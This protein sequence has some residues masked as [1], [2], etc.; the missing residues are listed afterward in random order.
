MRW[1]NCA[2]NSPPFKVPQGHEKW[3]ISIAYLRLLVSNQYELWDYL[4][5]F[6]R[7]SGIFVLKNIQALCLLTSLRV[8]AFRYCNCTRNQET[9]TMAQPENVKNWQY[10]HCIAKTVSLLFLEY[11]WC[12]LTD[13]IFFTTDSSHLPV[14]I[15]YF[16]ITSPLH[17]LKINVLSFK[18][19]RRKERDIINIAHHIPSDTHTVLTATFPGEPG[20]TSC[21]LNSPSP[22]IPGLCILLGQ[23]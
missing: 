6:L 5:P 23:T 19:L 12:R 17:L 11:L 20:L 9:R 2:P 7:Q 15:L 18:I 21:P 14:K 10:L 8:L 16:S 1:K 3:N 22:F 4:I 13:L